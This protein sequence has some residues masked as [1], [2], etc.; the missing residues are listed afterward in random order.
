MTPAHGASSKQGRDVELSP[1][2]SA[3]RCGDVSVTI[4][5]TSRT[6]LQEEGG[7][8]PPLLF[9]FLCSSRF[10]SRAPRSFL[11]PKKGK[12]GRPIRG[13]SLDHS[14]A[15]QLHFTFTRDLEAHLS[16]DCL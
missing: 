9:S 6:R 14:E 10:L 4:Y 1:S 8:S 3:S 11:W 13:I 5:K 2:P 15:L 16:L 7:L 12:V